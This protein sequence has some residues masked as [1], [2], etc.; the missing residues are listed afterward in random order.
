MIIYFLDL[1]ELKSG[2]KFMALQAPIINDETWRCLLTLK[3]SCCNIYFL[4]LG[5][6]K[7]EINF[8]ALYALIINDET[9]RC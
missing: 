7:S 9:W 8:T 4:D 3:A 2:R 6:L 5:E 1:G